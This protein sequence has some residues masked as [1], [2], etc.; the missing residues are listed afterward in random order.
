MKLNID[1]VRDVLLYLETIP[2]FNEDKTVNTTVFMSGK[3][4]LELTKKYSDDDI[5][6]SLKKLS[7]YDYIDISFSG[8]D[9][10]LIMYFGDITVDGHDFLKNIKSNDIWTSVK[11]T[12][13]SKALDVSLDILSSLASSYVLKSLNL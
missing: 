1:C 3:L 12:L 8:A 13:K 5:L 9:D 6:Y 11:E 2:F 4:P 7:E 10:Y